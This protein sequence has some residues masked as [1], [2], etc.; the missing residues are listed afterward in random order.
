[1]R[2]TNGTVGESDLEREYELSYELES[3]EEGDHETFDE[4]LEYDEGELGDDDGEMAREF[5]SL[6]E[7][8]DGTGEEMFASSSFGER[9]YELSLREYESESHLTAAV[10]GELDNMGE[11][12]FFGSLARRLKK[13]GGGLLKK[14]TRLAG[15]LPAMQALKGFTSLARNG[16]KGQLGSLITSAMASAIPGGAMAL[17]ALRALGINL[18]GG[19]PDRETYEQLAE[20]S[21]EAFEYLAETVDEEAN[22]PIRA[23]RL[24]SA[25]LQAGLRRAGG[26]R[27]RRHGSAGGAVRR[28]TLRRG[29][30]LII[31]A[32]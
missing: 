2:I 27:V 7:M 17:P 14:A 5:E 24:A 3:G 26:T 15:G 30:R 25:A 23:G 12:Y 32:G 1:M 18:P 11:E 9:L 10:L 8:E 28:I 22:N 31:S 29:E 6:R 4:E 13:A 19:T 20:I 21:R 16:L